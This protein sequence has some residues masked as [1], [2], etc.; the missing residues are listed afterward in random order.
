MTD[1]PTP[2]TPLEYSQSSPHGR[3]GLVTAVGVISIVIGCISALAG[4]QG[5]LSGVGLLMMSRMPAP[6]PVAVP[7][8]TTTAAT[9][10]V[11]AAPVGNP[12]GTINPVAAGLSIITS[13]IGLGLAIYLLVIGI[14]TLRYSPHA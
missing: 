12:F 4:L 2:V 6:A 5:T 13:G 10:P 14:L 3:P 9:A 11:T 8:P 7:A 1:H